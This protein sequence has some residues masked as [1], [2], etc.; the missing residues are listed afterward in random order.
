MDFQSEIAE[1][2]RAWRYANE[3]TRP[4]ARATWLGV[5]NTYLYR[6]ALVVRQAMS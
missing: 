5:A 3:T 4:E 1:A 6:A 2:Q